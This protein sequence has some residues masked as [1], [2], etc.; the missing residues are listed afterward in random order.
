MNLQNL[1]II[2]ETHG[3]Y[4]LMANF[5]V[6]L[7]GFEKQLQF[8][9]EIPRDPQAFP[10]SHITP[11]NPNP[12]KPWSIGMVFKEPTWVPE[13]PTIGWSRWLTTP[14][15]WRIV[16]GHD[17]PRLMGVASH[18]LSR[19]CKIWLMSDSQVKLMMQQLLQWNIFWN[20]N[21]FL[22]TIK[23]PMVEAIRVALK[24]YG[25]TKE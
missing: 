12:F 20:K 9:R 19:W 25:I 8:S 18:L 24:F 1:F 11:R 17:K 16:R 4:E 5:L 7:G 22:Q 15:R 13:G 10:Y 23:V 14:K 3:T 2:V 6:Y 21:I